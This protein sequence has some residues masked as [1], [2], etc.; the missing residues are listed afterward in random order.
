MKT[1][2]VAPSQRAAIIQVEMVEIPKGVKVNTSFR[3][4]EIV[5]GKVKITSVNLFVSCCNKNGVCYIR[6]ERWKNSQICRHR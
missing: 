4:G 2:H 6:R 5:E 1:E 3:S